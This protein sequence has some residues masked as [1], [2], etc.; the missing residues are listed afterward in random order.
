M[1]QIK[2]LLRGLSVKHTFLVITY[3]CS[4]YIKEEEIN[5]LE[6]LLYVCYLVV[7]L[8]EVIIHK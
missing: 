3:F 8:R 6:K 5:D 7:H 4:S 1:E 2:V